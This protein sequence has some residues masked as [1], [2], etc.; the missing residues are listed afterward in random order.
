[1]SPVST[2]SSTALSVDYRYIF[3]DTLSE[4]V[5]AELPLVDVN[6]STKLNEAGS[7]NGSF[8]ITEDVSVQEVYKNTLPGKTSLYVLR[9]GVCVWGGIVSARSY[10][11][12]EKILDISADEFL[13]YLDR[14]VVWKTWSTEYAVD[15]EIFADPANSSRIIGKATLAG[16]ATHEDFN[17]VAGKSKV[18]FSF[19]EEP[20]SEAD[21]NS[22]QTTAGTDTDSKDKPSTPVRT[23]AQYSGQYTVLNDPTYG[24]DTTDYKFFHFA[25]FYKPASAKNFRKLE[26]GNIDSEI[27]SVRFR[28]ETDDYLN[29]LLTRHFSDDLL[30]LSFANEYIAPARF[31]RYE[32]YSYSRSNN[33]ATIT[34]TDKNYFI[35]GQIVAVRDLPGFNTSRTKI[36]S[37]GSDNKTF[38]FAYTGANVTANTIASPTNYTITHYQRSNNIVSITTSVNHG[39]DEGD[40]VEIAGLDNRIDAEVKYLVTRIGTSAGPNP[41]VF[42]FYSPGTAIRFSKAP[43]G[44]TATK[45]PIVE[46]LTAGSFTDNSDIGIT[47]STNA[48]V[49]TTRAYQDAIRGAELF[50]FKEVI[51]KYAGDVLGFDYRID[52][53]YDSVT[54]TFSKEFKFL[55][56]KPESLTAAITSLPGGVLPQN[57]L[58][59]IEYFSVDG[60]NARGISFEFP[61]NIESVD[62]NETLEEGATR[63]FVQGKTDVDA[64]PPYAAF[65]DFDFLRG[66]LSDGRR[67]PIFDKVVKKDKMYYND[68]LYRVSKRILSEA[69]LPVATFSI[70]VNGTLNPQVGSYKPGDWCIVNIQDPFI[71]ERLSSYYENSGDTTRNVF[72]RKITSINVQLS[73]NPALPEQVSLELVTEPGVD[74]TGRETEWRVEE[75]KPETV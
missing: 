44:A 62:F 45:L 30:D 75:E 39:F 69:Q 8:P 73:N 14:R 63:V 68:D 42:Q 32:V 34:T 13:S 61:G 35:P 28:M 55:P 16:N 33:V 22:G 4:D 12:K 24:V 49:I 19:A 25:G 47:F 37:V 15:I 43:S 74:I 53:S 54:D 11:I 26:I 3:V 18:W 21:E 2:G 7:L 36:L 57:T 40:I 71:A 10:N 46:A 58:P 20:I 29:N 64:P 66:E 72:L 70:T 6:F 67:W 48:N 9:N 27:V 56:L 31:T 65:S 52:C 17:L 5:I 38:T 59:S 60:R 50:T 41:K 1:M 23:Y 51:D